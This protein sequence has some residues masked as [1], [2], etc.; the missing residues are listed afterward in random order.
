VN[1]LNGASPYG[2]PAAFGALVRHSKTTFSR[3][4]AM[5]CPVNLPSME[6]TKACSKCGRVKPLSL[7]T[8]RSRAKDGRRSACKACESSYNRNYNARA[9]ARNAN[10]VASR[11]AKMLSAAKHRAK[12][13]GW[14][15]DLDSKFLYSLVTD[16]C[17]I[18]GAP[19][20]WKTN[21]GAGEQG[22]AHPCAPS[23]DRIDS[24]RGYTKDNVWIISWKAN[25]LKN[26]AN[27]TE[28]IE[29]GLALAKAKMNLVC[30]QL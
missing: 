11:I 20:R 26:D 9:F 28:L 8:R 4:M 19:F 29:L 18:T 1:V 30:S 17:P 15:F 2:S 12:T 13:K 7:F 14:E 16:N 27:E 5:L 6:G 24:S 22:N 21:Y 10:P 23:L 25:C 3:A